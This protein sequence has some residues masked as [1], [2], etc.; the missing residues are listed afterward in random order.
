VLLA[1]LLGKV[2]IM[3]KSLRIFTALSVVASSI[4]FATPS[5]AATVGG[6]D[7]T[8]SGTVVMTSSSANRSSLAS[9]STSASDRVIFDFG[10]VGF[11]VANMDEVEWSGQ[12]AVGIPNSATLNYDK[13][14]NLI[15]GYGPAASIDVYSNGSIIYQ[16]TGFPY[17]GGNTWT[18]FAQFNY[19][20][21][22][23]VVSM[24]VP[25]VSGG[26]WTG[27]TINSDGTF[28]LS[29]GTVAS[30]VELTNF[31]VGAGAASA[32]GAPTSVTATSTGATTANVSF[33]APASDGGATITSYT[34]TSSPGGITGSISQA[35]S[36]TIAMT[37]LTAGTSYTF[38]V[39]ATNSAGTGSASSASN[40]ITTVGAPSYPTSVVATAT[41][42]RS[43]TVSFGA[44]SSN[45]G[46]A[47]TSYTATSTP[48]GITKTLT[49]ATGGTF[50]FD[51]LLPGTAYT[52][53]VTA[54][55]AIGTSAAATS[56]SV[57]TIPLVV[58][59]L[60]ALSF[61]DD[62]TGTGGKIVWAGT[63][64]DAVLYT[65]PAN[66]YPGPYNYGAFTSGW[67][68]RIRNL[69][70]DTSYT[71]S[72]YAISADGVGGE[73]SLTFK[74]N[75]STNVLTDSTTSTDPNGG[76]VVNIGLERGF[77]WL[78]IL[79]TWLK[80]NTFVTGE[81][82][83]MY[84]LLKK[85]FQLETSPNSI[86]IKVPT[87]RVSDV[88]ATSLTP[89]TCSVISTTENRDDAGLVTAL[90]GGTC[91]ISY[92]VS[93]GSSAPATMVRDFVFSKYVSSPQSFACGDGFYTITA[94][95]VSSGESC[96]GAVTIDPS[97]TS[98]EFGAF[99]DSTMSSISIPN[100]VT[101][102]PNNAFASSAKLT[103]VELGNAV[104]N[105]GIFAFAGTG[106][107]S[108]SLPVALRTIGIGAFYGTSLT[109]ITIPEGTTSVD[110]KAFSG[111]RKLETIIIPSTITD[112]SELALTYSWFKTVNYCGS[113]ASVLAAIAK[114][115]IAATCVAP[116]IKP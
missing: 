61:T 51:G 36:G 80:D 14:I 28:A 29:S 24:R 42:K 81:A 40:S 5:H 16:A 104:T 76:I 44:P 112:M 38:T 32:P 33:T 64:I 79:E 10:G 60:S 18:P 94:G 66:S 53:A 101:A 68:G 109:S 17:G 37:G 34:A 43:A 97:A 12:G 74:T 65:G 106:L 57:T 56:N 92:T 82:S 95:V 49:Q 46:S 13:T 87:S 114:Q 111:N 84:V 85:F 47:V 78:S 19:K 93:G 8:T 67:N 1:H 15:V 4:L 107:V 23:G 108:I 22:T 54:T 102:I 35:G 55:N 115:P 72:I 103:K 70:P 20:A 45:N 99:R 113:D 71:V 11:S 62:G 9:S 91:T 6:V 69:T 75:A 88:V 7:V 26:G 50:T 83:N 110:Y 52:F 105:I 89:T 96:T 77:Y 59:S 90:S 30:W 21:S 116:A 25:I 63:S 27:V 3:K 98:I 86:N 41:G 73:K 39:T 100:S 31:V 2:V 48:G 58:A